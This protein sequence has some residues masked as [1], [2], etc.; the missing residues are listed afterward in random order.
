MELWLRVP[1]VTVARVMHQ[2]NEKE[3]DWTISRGLHNMHDFRL[4]RYLKFWNIVVAYQTP[5]VLAEHEME[6]FAACR[7]VSSIHLQE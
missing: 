5:Y 3:F 2:I 7:S 1:L 4:F 6:E